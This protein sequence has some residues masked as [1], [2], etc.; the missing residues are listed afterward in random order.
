MLFFFDPQAISTVEVSLSHATV[1]SPDFSWTSVVPRIAARSLVEG[2]PGHLWDDFRIFWIYFFGVFQRI[3]TKT[4]ENHGKNNGKTMETTMENHG[5]NHGKQTLPTNP[6]AIDSTHFSWWTVILGNSEIVTFRQ[7][8]QYGY[9]RLRT[10]PSINSK[11]MVDQLTTDVFSIITRGLS[12]CSQCHGNCS[13]S[14]ENE[15]A[16][17]LNGRARSLA[18][19]IGLRQ[20]KLFRWSIDKLASSTEIARVK[21]SCGVHTPRKDKLMPLHQQM[22]R[23]KHWPKEWKKALTSL[24]SAPKLGSLKLNASRSCQ[25]PARCR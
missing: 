21:P 7:N 14:C 19:L 8:G 15:L 2:C 4:M 23:E 6:L 17:T 20:V 25:Q 22:S 1:G 16:Q 3:S 9:P 13:G 5:N 11:M 12:V 24:T 10:V 18:L